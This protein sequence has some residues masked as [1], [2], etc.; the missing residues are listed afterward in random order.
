MPW[1]RE[2]K[3]RE[4]R[5]RGNDKE[6]KGAHVWGELPRGCRPKLNTICRIDAL[7]Q[8]NG[9]ERGQKVSSHGAGTPKER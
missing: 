2:W 9:Q 6:N 3:W 7:N 8:A 1:G 5:E 4:T